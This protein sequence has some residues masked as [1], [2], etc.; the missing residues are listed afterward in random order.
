MNNTEE[1]ISDVADRIKEVTQS[2]QQTEKQMKKHES[3]VRDLWDKIKCP[4]YAK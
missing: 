1:G 3:N 2:G 4:I